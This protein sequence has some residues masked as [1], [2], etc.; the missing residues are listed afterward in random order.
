MEI[1]WADII[2]RARTYVDDDHNATKGWIKPERWLV[3]A[4]IE[5]EQLWRRWVRAGLVGPAWTDEEFTGPTVE[6]EDPVYAILGV[7]EVLGE[8]EYR[9]IEPLQPR[10]GRA[11]F[12]NS[13]NSPASGWEARG[14]ADELTVTVYPEDESGTYVAR[15][16]ALPE[17]TDDP[18]DTVALPFG[19][20]ERLVLGLARRALVKESAQSAAINNLIREAEEELNFTA[21]ARM[22][23]L[24][25][26]KVHSTPRQLF[27]ADPR[28]WSYYR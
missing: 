21:S 5:Y 2:D 24:R 11:P 3:L 15:Y 18:A 14:A 6:L 16:I 23:G 13:F 12:R 27:P 7:A 1:S 19:G 20:D 8:G 10:D 22:G 25:V 26:R 17:R 9:P 28:L 4:Q